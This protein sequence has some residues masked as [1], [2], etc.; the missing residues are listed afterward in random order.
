MK[1]KNKIEDYNKKH[2]N[3]LPELISE[4]IILVPI[5]DSEEFY[6][7]YHKWLSNEELK[8]KLGEE[9]MDYTLQEIREMHDEWKKDLKNMTFCI[10]DRQTKEPIGDI[11]LFDSGEFNNKAEMSIMLGEHAGKGFGTEAS[12]VIMKF[13][14]KELKLSEINLSVYKDNDAAVKLYKKLGFRITG[15]KKDEDNREEYLMKIEA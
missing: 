3:K 4:R 10:L 7:L 2:G 13:A 12:E 9:K 14:F 15:E 8:L 5:P 6:A 1:T 11:N